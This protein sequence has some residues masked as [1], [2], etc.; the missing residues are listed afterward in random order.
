M[1][2]PDTLSRIPHCIYNMDPLSLANL[3]IHFGET[4][5]VDL[6]HCC[7]EPFYCATSK[8]FWFV[9]KYSTYAAGLT[10]CCPEGPTLMV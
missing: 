2:A 3:P 10:C 9:K 5:E 8:R 4:C 6:T 1:I 7:T